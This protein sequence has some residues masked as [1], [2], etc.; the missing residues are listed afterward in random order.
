MLGSFVS[1]EALEKMQQI[2]AI[3][4]RAKALGVQ[5]GVL[6]PSGLDTLVD[7]RSGGIGVQ[8][9]KVK[10]GRFSWRVAVAK[11]IKSIT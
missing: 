6:S 5:P 4:D 11:Q 10:S 2:A 9:A 8:F 7:I 3:A 1:K